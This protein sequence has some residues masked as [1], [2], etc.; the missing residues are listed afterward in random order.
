MGGGTVGTTTYPKA[1]VAVRVLAGLLLLGWAVTL[2]LTLWTLPR[3]S[4]PQQLRAD[5]ADGRVAGY[6]LVYALGTRQ[7]PWNVTATGFNTAEAAPGIAWSLHDGRT[8]W[9]S[10]TG[11]PI[12]LNSSPPQ[13]TTSLNPDGT[14]VPPK[15]DPAVAPLVTALD[16]AGATRRLA[17]QDRLQMAVGVIGITALILLLAGPPPQRGTKWF[18][19]WIS[20]TTLGVGLAAWLV[21]EHLRPPR[22]PVARR[23]RGLAGFVISLAAGFALSFVLSFGV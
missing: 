21:L 14:T 7:G 12:D 23:Q 15:P 8:R 19:F 13:D 16:E 17:E 2:A 10:V 20:T 9:A 5:I 18:W 4:T 22:Q 11:A 6:R 1:R 3:E